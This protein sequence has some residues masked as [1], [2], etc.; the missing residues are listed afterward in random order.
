M[1]IRAGLRRLLGTGD[2]R[3]APRRLAPEVSPLEGRTLQAVNA[4][5]GFLKADPPVL[6]PS[7]RYVTVA[8]TGQI[9][10]NH[11]NPP[12]AFFFVT[13][14][15]R[16]DEPHGTGIPLT[17]VETNKKNWDIYS[18]SFTIQLQ[19]KRSTRTPDGRHY[20]LFVGASDNDD[21]DGLTLQIF[22]PKVYPG[23]TTATRPH[24]Q[25]KQGKGR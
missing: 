11:L 12:N 3:R 8:V 22:V 20:D 17:F 10:F 24:V 14:E 4:G 6:A 2:A 13:D 5:Q 25:V 19:A 21:T 18:Y 9:G 1:D 15:Y 23:T 16:S 7:G